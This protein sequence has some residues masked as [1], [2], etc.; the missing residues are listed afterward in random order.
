MVMNKLLPI[1]RRFFVGCNYWASHAGTAMWSD[2]RP[3]QVEL[4]LDRLADAGIDVLRVFPLWPDFQPIESLYTACGGQRGYS[5]GEEP[6]PDSKAGQAGV[7][8]QMMERFRQ[9][10]AMAERRGLKLIV[11]LVTGWMSGRLF[12]PPALRGKPILTDPEAIRWQVKFVRYFVEEMRACP[13]II[14]W[15]L[16]NEC[17]V[18][19]HVANRQEAYVWTAALSGAIKS[20]DAS[21]PLISGMHSLS[22]AGHWT[23]Q[24]QG[25]LTDILT[26]HPYPFWTPFM[27]VD[28]IDTMRPTMHAAMENLF[29]SGLGGKPCFAEEMGTMGPMVCGEETAAAFARTSMLTQWAHGSDGLLWWCANDQTLLRHAPYE[30]MAC[31]GELGLLTEEGC[32]KPAL[33]EMAALKNALELLPLE[34]LPPRK[35]D[36]VCILNSAQDHWA[37]AAGAFMLAKQAG[38]DIEFRYEEQSLPDADFY[39]LPCV[40]GVAGVP[41]RRWEQLLDKARGGATLYVSSNDGY[42]LNFSELTGLTVVNRRRRA[43]AAEVIGRWN[44]TGMS[45]EAFRFKVYSQF[46]LDFRCDRAEVLAVEADGN[47]VLVRTAYGKGTIFFCSLPVEL[48]MAQQPEVSYLPEQTPYWRVYEAIS[49]EARSKRLLAIDS[50]HVGTT[51]HDLDDD[52]TMAVLIN[53]SPQPQVVSARLHPGWHLASYWYGE[54]VEKPEGGDAIILKLAANDGLI[55]VFNRT[56][57]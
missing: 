1:E 32:V 43:E 2:W 31:E 23:M 40:T 27:D 13:A 20:S 3:E 57:S 54:T 55:L 46:R 36:G 38:F 6:L 8:V 12:V 41:K 17:N 35:V 21:R 7:S 5:F 16:G 51:E 18:M 48:A 50:P 28:P 33:K 39:L 11:G 47:P 49:S 26:T 14:A 56:D 37:A 25:E 29:Y 9:L 45:D 30:W 42:M 19:G 4:D 34:Q 15:D 53:Y 22:P 10:A 52:R 44:H 24:D